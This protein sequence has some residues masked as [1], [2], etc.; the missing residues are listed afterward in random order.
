[1]SIE[2]MCGVHLV[3]VWE[4]V[5]TVGAEMGTNYTPTDTG[6]RLVCSMQQLSANEVLQF[7]AREMR[8]SH[9]AYF[10]AD[11]GLTINNLLKFKGAT[12]RVRGQ[13][14][15]SDMSGTDRLWVVPCEEV[16]SRDV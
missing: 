6:R 5:Q 3:Q 12:M 4:N 9:Q 15:E 2:A 16:T 8:V 14:A 13:Y 10:S 7:K 1:M 11:P